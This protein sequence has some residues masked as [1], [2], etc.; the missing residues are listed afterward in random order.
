MNELFQY[1]KR[2]S[3]SCVFQYTLLGFYSSEKKLLDLIL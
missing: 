1:E 2:N 3:S